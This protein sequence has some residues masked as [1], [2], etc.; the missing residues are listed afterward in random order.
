VSAVQRLAGL[1]AAVSLVAA[2]L[3]GCSEAE[4]Q[5]EAESAVCGSIAELRQSVAGLRELDA[6]STGEDAK[7]AVED[8]RDALGQVRVE[9]QDLRAADET[10]VDTA[11]DAVADNVAQIDDSDTLGAAADA[12]RTAAAPLEAVVDQVADGLGC[13]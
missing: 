6:D 2:G 1:A 5:G 13:P 12:L 7:A 10:A 4:T 3:A 11:V 9:A 8:V